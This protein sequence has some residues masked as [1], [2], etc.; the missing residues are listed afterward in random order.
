[1]TS[2]I[3]LPAEYSIDELEITNNIRLN[4]VPSENVTDNDL[5]SGTILDSIIMNDN[6]LFFKYGF[7]KNI[8][9]EMLNGI[10]LIKKSFTIFNSFQVIILKNKVI[11]LESKF[12]SK[13]EM[14]E[15]I[16]FIEHKIIKGSLGNNL[17]FEE[18][19]LRSLHN[20][21]EMHGF[22]IE[23]AHGNNKSIDR[24]S[25]RGKTDI[26]GTDFYDNYFDEPLKKVT[27][28]FEGDSRKEVRISF[29]LKGVIRIYNQ[30]LTPNQ[31]LA[32]LRFVNSF[33][34]NPKSIKKRIDKSQKKLILFLKNKE[35]SE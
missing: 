23:P 1:M 31:I 16:D 9:R 14:K 25:G 4:G 5:R 27:I 6:G 17:E 33:I 24:I 29:N 20:Y 28:A 7:E 30:N 2:F 26:T 19:F 11:G 22:D 10:Q 15:I 18:D 12:S 13:K 3:L 32:I 34:N 21:Y 35:E 8:D